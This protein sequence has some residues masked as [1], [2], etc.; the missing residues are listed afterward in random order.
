MTEGTTPKLE[1]IFDA[2]IEELVNETAEP[3]SYVEAL[4]GEGKKFK[5]L[6]ALAKS[7]LEADRHIK[8]LS[9]T[10]ADLKS[11]GNTY[12]EI[13]EI[14]KKTPVE[15]PASSSTAN[16][17]VDID[18]LVDSKFEA[19]ELA[20]LAAENTDKSLADLY[21][22]YGSEAKGKQALKKAA[23]GDK[24]IQ[25]MLTLLGSKNPDAFVKYVKS[26]VAI[27]S[28]TPSVS[29]PG[30]EVTTSP[31]VVSTDSG[32]LT[33]TKAKEIR[34]TDP[35]R[36]NSPAFRKQLNDAAALSEK[37]GKDFYAT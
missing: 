33:W 2:D 19:K 7:K 29:T 26:Q 1:S 16:T 5:D 18:K 22:A 36:Y 31:S 28:T 32:G 35:K 34:K 8:D 4:V 21:E 15:A 6:E 11:K 14:L 25:S 24:A 30:F 37:R 10:I 27:D 12:Q 9:D 13:L 3:D 23:G 20:R 17:E